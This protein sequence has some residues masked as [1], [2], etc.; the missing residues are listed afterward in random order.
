MN[1]QHVRALSISMAPALVINDEPRP[2]WS[3]RHRKDPL[4]A[5]QAADRAVPGCRVHVYAAYTLAQF[6]TAP[7][8]PTSGR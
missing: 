6:W 4:T 7:G 1:R 8:Q 3:T 5:W 2:P